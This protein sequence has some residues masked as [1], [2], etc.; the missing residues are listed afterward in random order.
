L[1]LSRVKKAIIEVNANGDCVIASMTVRSRLIKGLIS[2]GIEKVFIF[3]PVGQEIDPYTEFANEKEGQVQQLQLLDETI[4]DDTIIIE[5][6]IIFHNDVLQAFVASDLRAIKDPYNNNLLVSKG[7]LDQRFDR[8]ELFQIDPFFIFKVDVDNLVEAKKRLFKYLLKPTDGFVSKHLNR[9]ISTIFS[10]ILS[11]YPVVPA[12]LTGVTALFA[13]VMF[14]ALILAEKIGIGWGC[15]L[16]HVTSVVDGIDGEIARVKF[17]STRRGAMLDT[18]ID[19]A[20]NFLFMF[21]LI[22][23][24]W[25]SSGDEYIVKGVIILTLMLTGAALMYIILY[26][27]PGGGSFDIL[28]IVIRKKIGKKKDLLRSFVFFNYLLKRDTFALV[29]AVLGISGYA[30]LIVEL[31]VGGLIIWNVAIILNARSIIRIG[32]DNLN[33][34]KL[35]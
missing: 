8:K 11:D 10:N 12:Y 15:F 27:G 9:P 2:I 22:F 21:G 13:V 32:K 23:A 34:K 28:S 30:G 5:D 1:S 14:L 29:F 6:G 25:D 4:S 19:M 35:V 3:D 33:M 31:L 18:T 26:F 20:T 16:F 24:L 17:Q 7:T